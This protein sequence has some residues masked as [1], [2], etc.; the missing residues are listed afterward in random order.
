MDLLER[1]GEAVLIT[2][3]SRPLLDREGD[4]SHGYDVPGTGGW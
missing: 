3:L 4:T 2:A 1:S